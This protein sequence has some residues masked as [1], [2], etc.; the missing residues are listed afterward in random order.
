MPNRK[1]TRNA[2][3]GGSIRQRPDGRWEAR[4]TVGRDPGTGKQVQKSV[5]G[6]TEREVRKKLTQ[7]TAAIDEGTYMEPSK[8][9]VGAWLDIW[10]KEYTGHIKDAT[11]R[12]YKDSVRLYL[13]PAIGAVQL[14]KLNSHTIQKLYNDLSTKGS[15]K[16]K[17]TGLSPKTVRIIH[18]ILHKALKQ[19][20]LIGYMKHNPSIAC[21]LPRMEK[22]KMNILPADELSKFIEASED[23][24]YHALF[25]V[26]LF[27]GMR[28]G[29]ALGLKWEDVDSHRG[30]IHIRQQMQRE[31]VENGQL[32]LVSLKNDRQRQITPAQTIFQIL[33]KH[34]VKQS[35]TRLMVGQAWAD[36]GLVFCNDLG[37]FLDADAIYKSY[38]RFLS[39][40][41]LTEM[42]L[43][44]LR[45]TAAT[46]MLENG[47]HIKSVQEA[48][49]HHSAAFTLD[50]YGHVTPEMKREDADRMERLIQ[51]LKSG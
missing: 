3:G 13:K 12:S 45:H 16:K 10:L 4:Y 33:H 8:L 46:L 9:T 1:T 26:Y 39:N 27:T 23:H 31:R 38:K 14:Q 29:K 34:K 37:N 18:G 22:K 24:K 6:D 11:L 7:A 15:L 32:R 50:V 19:A 36:H 35:E 30:V 40:N 48:L 47:A 25:M 21:T 5:Y 41:G 28:R 43:H 2:Q 20:V 49:G 44:D 42:R 51:S 17:D